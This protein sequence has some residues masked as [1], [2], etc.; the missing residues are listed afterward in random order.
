MP[1]TDPR[2]K[3]LINQYK[4]NPSNA[5]KFQTAE[6]GC[7]TFT[8]KILDIEKWDNL[9]YVKQG[10]KIKLPSKKGGADKYLVTGRIR[11]DEVEHLSDEP[12]V[13]SIK[14]SRKLHPVS[15]KKNN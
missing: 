15:N 1:V 6:D 7:M 13:Q 2:T 3:I 9:D 10:T 14:V 11:I 12:F 4:E 8:A 5:P